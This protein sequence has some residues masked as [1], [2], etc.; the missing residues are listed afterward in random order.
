MD[1][2]APKQTKGSAVK[3]PPPQDKIVRSVE[4]SAERKNFT[5]SLRENHRGRFVRITEQTGN[6]RST[7]IVPVPALANFV[8]KLS[9]L[10]SDG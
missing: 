2:P 7:V 4:F 6:N 3:R 1:S 9:E 8:A 10:Q 5:L